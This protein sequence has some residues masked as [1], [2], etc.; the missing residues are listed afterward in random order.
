M[1]TREE[2]QLEMATEVMIQRVHE[3]KASL[4]SLMMRLDHDHQ[5][6]TFPEFLDTF[7]VIS[8]QV[9]WPNHHTF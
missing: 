8:G 1:G 9:G 7:S 6:I 2:K 4:T 5:H 3:M